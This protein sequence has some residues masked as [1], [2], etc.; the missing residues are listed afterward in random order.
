MEHLNIKIDGK[1][2]KYAEITAEQ[3]YCFYDVDEE[4]RQY[5]EKIFT[6]ITDAQEL[7]RKYIAVQGD[8]EELNA[9]LEKQRLKEMENG[10]NTNI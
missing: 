2:T 10:D 4:E 8:A 1:Y 3:G 9:E 7:K 5:A 6:P